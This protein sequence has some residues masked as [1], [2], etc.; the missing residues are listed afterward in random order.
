MKE[1]IN[2]AFICDENYVLCTGVAVFSLYQNRNPQRDYH[3]YLFTD[4]V[5]EAKKNILLTQSRKGFQVEVIDVS[6]EKKYKQFNRMRFAAHV[7]QAAL[8]KFELAELLKQ[9]EK[10]L[11]LDGDILIR[12]SLEELY[13]TDIEGRY[14]AVCKDLGAESF[15]SP[16]RSRLKIDS[17]SYFNSGVMLLNLKL[18][19]ED[20]IAQKLIDYKLN[21]INDFMDQDAFNVV[22]S[23][24]VTYYSF[25]Y[26]M[27]YSCWSKNSCQTLCDYYS[28]EM[29]SIEDFYTK[30][31][32]VHFCTPK[33]PW[34]FYNVIGAEEWF[35]YYIDSPLR[36]L[37]NVR[38]CYQKDILNNECQYQTILDYL[39]P[40]KQTQ[41][42]QVSVIT[43]VYNAEKYLIPCIESLLSQT[44]QSFEAIFVDDGSKD[45]SLSILQK[46][47]A[48]DE[49][50]KIFTQPNQFAGM[51]RNNGIDHATGKYITF[52]DSDDL[53]VPE[54]LEQFFHR[55]E[56]TQ[57]DVVISAAWH[58][59]EDIH[60]RSNAGWCLR[61]DFLPLSPV[62]DV[63]ICAKHI[64]QISAGA[65]WGKFYKRDFLNR[66]NIRFPSLPRSEDVLFVY[67]AIVLAQKISTISTPTILYRNG[68]GTES[69][70]G[71]KD[72]SPLAPVDGTMLLYEK[73]NEL[74]I[75]PLVRQSF[76]NNAAVRI[77]YNMKGFQTSAALEKMYAAIKDTFFPLYGEDLC[78]PAFYYD[79]GK[80][81]ELM[82]I[83]NSA[84]CLDYVFSKY[85][86]ALAQLQKIKAPSAEGTSSKKL[87]ASATAPRF[88][89]PWVVRKIKGGVQ[90]YKDHGFRYTL[91]HLITKVKRRLRGEKKQP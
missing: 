38:T 50:I 30:A 9:E 1:T 60:E 87:R 72:R 25:L 24:N 59:C 67:W 14:A 11:Y 86:S 64:F 62:F 78:D 82:E 47:A 69:L 53:M 10:L 89:G 23:Q 54:A 21:G 61:S 46:Y 63:T 76:L 48:M 22:F 43:P 20:G 58:F 65:P 31:K 83:Q 71:G 79:K 91:R 49:R 18:M 44:F 28:I 81:A 40:R 26:N 52:L 2:I 73:L 36:K 57:A 41:E 19:R 37:E 17:D 85:Q 90:C 74:G 12:D 66:N 45:A 29:S 34:L 4:Q 6:E 15:P 5:P 3:I 32:I 13:E 42:T 35:L 75:Y 8:L 68:N 70:E 51:A 39:H 27:L 33:K 77:A 56:Q 80:F 7:S 84:S 16:F 88:T 55:A